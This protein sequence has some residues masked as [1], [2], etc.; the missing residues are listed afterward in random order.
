MQYQ[1]CTGPRFTLPHHIHI[2]VTPTIGMCLPRRNCVN[3]WWW[4]SVWFYCRSS[5]TREGATCTST[6]FE[7]ALYRRYCFFFFRRAFL[8][9]QVHLSLSPSHHLIL[10]HL[11]PASAIIC[12]FLP[13][14]GVQIYW[15]CISL[16]DVQG[17]VIRDGR[18][19]ISE[20]IF[21]FQLVVLNCDGRGCLTR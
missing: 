8:W 1:L 9:W 17:K 19:E 4:C 12:D 3:C 15:L 2:F 21:Y 6:A 10:L 5:H 7:G 14:L 18:A 20:F 11:S 16:A 13:S